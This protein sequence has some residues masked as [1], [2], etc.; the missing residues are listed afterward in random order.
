MN[1]K[2]DDFV[3]INGFTTKEEFMAEEQKSALPDGVTSIKFGGKPITR[4]WTP[5]NREILENHYKAT[6]IWNPNLC[7]G[8][9]ADGLLEPVIWFSSL[10]YK[11][12][13]KG[14]HA[15]EFMRHERE[16]SDHLMPDWVMRE[17]SL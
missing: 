14:E 10:Y 11:I 13:E 1:N 12:T 17:A 3:M 4:V 8:L 6:A 7:R 16:T 5:T 2:Y 15:V 9:V